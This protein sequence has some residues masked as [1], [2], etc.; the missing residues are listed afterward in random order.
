MTRHSDLNQD[1]QFLFVYSII[2]VFLSSPPG[3]TSLC[4]KA[5]AME[6]TLASLQM[7]IH[8][9]SSV[10]LISDLTEYNG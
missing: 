3:K 1:S 9:Y 6:T 7:S 5:L 2:V 10:S 4:F 8:V